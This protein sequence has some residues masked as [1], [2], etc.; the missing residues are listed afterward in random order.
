[1]P[2]KPRD[3]RTRESGRGSDRHAILKLEVR[4]NFTGHVKLMD[5]PLKYSPAVY[6]LL[7]RYKDSIQWE[8][9]T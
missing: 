3:F 1:M 4:P 7:A 2:Y 9:T 8:T 6:P 5:C